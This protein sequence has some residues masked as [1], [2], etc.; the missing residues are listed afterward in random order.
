MGFFT[1]GFADQDYD[2]PFFSGSDGSYHSPE[3]L[4]EWAA[5]QGFEL[6]ANDDGEVVGGD[7]YGADEVADF[8]DDY[9]GEWA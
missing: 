5:D 6:Y 2:D 4:S 7:T 9:E 1:D 3:E 8:D